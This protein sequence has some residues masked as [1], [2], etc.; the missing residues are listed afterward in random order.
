MLRAA[1]AAEESFSEPEWTFLP[2]STYRYAVRTVSFAN[3]ELES[4]IQ[5]LWISVRSEAKPQGL[6]PIDLPAKRHD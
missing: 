2:L 1:L 5:S 4:G 6:K 3:F